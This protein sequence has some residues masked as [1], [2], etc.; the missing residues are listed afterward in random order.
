MLR[1]IVLLVFILI[2]LLVMTLVAAA[3]LIDPDDYRE[4]LATRAS[5]Q[6][7]R[8][9]Q[10]NGP[11]DLTYF[12]WLALDISDV[13]VG[14]PADFPEAPALA[15]IQ[16]ASASVRLLPLLTGNLEV[17]TVGVEDARLSV[18]TSRSGATNL[19]GLFEGGAETAPRDQPTNLTG[20]STG[21][22]EFRNV[23]LSLVD[24]GAN[25]RT[26][27]ELVRLSLAPFAPGREVSFDLSARLLDGDNV[28]LS[29]ALDG[30]LNVAA[31]LGEIRVSDWTLDYELPDAGAAGEASGSLVLNPS[32]QPISVR[33]ED[34]D[35]ALEAAGMN[36]GL[37]GESPITA[38]LGDPIRASLPGAVLD[39]D[40]QRLTLD[41]EATVGE[42]IGGRLEVTGERLDLT[43]LAPAGGDS[44][45]STDPG[46]GGAPSDDYSGLRVL[47]L[48]F[49]LD[50]G[51]LVLTEGARLT[52]VTARSRMV[53]GQLSLDPLS[54][55][56]FGG[57][58][59]GS[60]RVDFNQQP[61]EVVVTPNL[62]GIRVAELAGLLTGQSPVDGEG[63]VRMDVRFSGFTPEQMLS[64]LNGGGD[65]SVADGV[66][67]GV[68]L[69][70]LI[71]QELT[72][73]NL[74]NIARTFGGQTQFRTLEG[75]M[76]I[77][78]GVV[79][80]PSMNLS[81]AG[82]SASGQG[83]IDLG[84]GSVDYA[85]ALDLGAELTQQLPG[86]LRR[87]TNGQIPLKIA[88]PLNRPTVSVD[89]A[90]LAEGVVR[91]E[92]GR[93]LLEAL[94]DD[95]P[96]E[97]A[98]ASDSVGAEG[99]GEPAAA[100][101]EAAGEERSESDQRRDAARSLLRGLLAPE[102]EEAQAGDAEEAKPTEE[103]AA[104]EDDPPPG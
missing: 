52:E 41:G 3:F 62:S 37:S 104:A 86:A 26:E 15:S 47:D 61:P 101:D 102:E 49:A 88:G 84:A 75:G 95:E 19:E 67:Q 51:E 36:L 59:D 73:S 43:R 40:G 11:I 25:T 44:A 1:K 48:Q 91:E 23:V 70:A 83:R 87:S 66:L 97:Q 64:S 2:A 28:M 99:D 31:D 76:Q 50:L 7:G 89:L 42:R 78:D 8:Q 17:G 103:E 63:E 5:E 58:F 27:I 79:S 4:E 85:L 32:A 21:P 34:F 16:R 65:F 56:L 100:G 38:S 80:L 96:E 14:N 77:N 46:D 33:L 68:D 39:L 6:L 9:V 18:V 12:P 82:Y 20:V 57:R 69:Q 81:A 30:R 94:E 53:D 92:L 13:S 93:R 55:R 74:T 54:A 29:A 45:G 72:T 60:A 98:P 22:V 71:D 90:S 35:S 24:L 10:L